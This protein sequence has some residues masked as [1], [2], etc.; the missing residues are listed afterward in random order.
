[1]ERS[2]RGFINERRERAGTLPSVEDFAT[3]IADTCIDSSLISGATV[4]V[5]S[6]EW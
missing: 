4:F 1:M 5:G 6:T 3:A 2:T